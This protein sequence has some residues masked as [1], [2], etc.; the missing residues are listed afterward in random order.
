MQH[1]HHKET[2]CIIASVLVFC[3][4]AGLGRASA[5]TSQ[6]GSSRTPCGC[7][8]S[9]LPNQFQRPRTRHEGGYGMYC[10]T[11]SNPCRQATASARF[12]R[13]LRWLLRM[14]WVHVDVLG[15]PSWQYLEQLQSLRHWCLDHGSLNCDNFNHNC[16]NASGD[17]GCGQ[18]GVARMLP[19]SV[20]QCNTSVG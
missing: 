2:K 8:E 9:Q 12:S 16:H 7:L 1:R 17:N 14:C 5:W 10:F 11:I 18:R 20:A 3:Q 4:I 13:L 6:T 19:S 15:S